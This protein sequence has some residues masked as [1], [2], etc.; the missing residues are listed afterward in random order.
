MFHV[1]HLPSAPCLKGFASPQKN[2]SDKITLV[3][4]LKYGVY[5]VV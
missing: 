5:E 1:K 2:S 3:K 4:A